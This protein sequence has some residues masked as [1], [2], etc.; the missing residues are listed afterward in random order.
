MPN[1]TSVAASSGEMSFTRTEE[2]AISA[3]HFAGAVPA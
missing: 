2:S 1:V 3:Y